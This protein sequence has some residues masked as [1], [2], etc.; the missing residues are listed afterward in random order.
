MKNILDK[1]NRADEIQSKVEL[2]KHEVELALIDDLKEIVAKGKQVQGSMVEGQLEVKNIAQRT[3]QFAKEHLKNL[4]NVS[5]LY[6]QMK[7][8]ADGLGIDITKVAEYRSAFDFLNST[9]KAAT[10]VIIKKLESLK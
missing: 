4:D 8:Q 3:L 6:N 2:G 5:K 9:P 7:T 1:I 10:E